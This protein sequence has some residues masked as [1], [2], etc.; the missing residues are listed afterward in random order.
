MYA[1]A[2]N[3]LGWIDPLGLSRCNVNARAYEEKNTEYVRW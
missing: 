2:P 3:S 1:Y